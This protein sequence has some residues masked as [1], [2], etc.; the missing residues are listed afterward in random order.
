MPPPGKHVLVEAYPRL[1]SSQFPPEDRNG[2]QHDAFAVSAWLHARDAD[3]SLDT[4][5][6]PDLAPDE[7]HVASV[8]GWIIGL[9]NGPVTKAKPARKA[10]TKAA[11]GPHILPGHHCQV[12]LIVSKPTQGDILR[13]VVE[14]LNDKA[15]RVLFASELAEHR[16][17]KELASGA[18]SVVFIADVTVETVNREPCAYRVTAVQ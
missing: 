4:Y 14:S 12:V 11:S 9:K 6:E 3:G 17:C 18:S 5:F 16:I 1:F 13:G 15:L 10:I 8:E 7:R 2:D